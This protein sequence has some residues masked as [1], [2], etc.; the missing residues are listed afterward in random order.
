MKILKQ[1]N[2]CSVTCFIAIGVCALCAT[3]PSK[4]VAFDNAAELFIQL[5]QQATPKPPGGRV[6]IQGKEYKKE[7]VT[8]LPILSVVDHR[9]A[10]RQFIQSISTYARRQNRNFM[11]VTKDGL[12][13]LVKK[14]L[15]DEKISLPA[16]TYM[17]SIDAVMIDGLFYGR[18]AFG[19]PT[20]KKVLETRLPL[21]NQA[22]KNGIKT[23]A[24]EY[25]KSPQEAQ[26]AIKLNTA[27]GLIPFPSMTPRNVLNEIPSYPRRP[28]NENPKSILSMKDV[29]N[30]LYLRETAKFGRQDEFTLNIH[31]TNFDLVVVDIFH[32]RTPLSRQAVETLKYKKVGAKRLVFA[33]IDIG[34]ASSHRYYWKARW[35]EGSPFWIKAPVPG[36]PD[37]YFVQFS[38]PEWRRIISGNPKSYVF[39]AIKQGFDGIILEGINAYRFFEGTS[40]EAGSKSGSGGGPL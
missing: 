13:L 18:Q 19:L 10:M 7:S 14:D 39:G 37:R 31:G 23:F 25:V 38:Q 29:K 12:D 3:W 24:I 5:A 9:E 4:S 32:G 40:S 20:D 36:E 22:I 16:R 30:F 27:R 33:H 34:T 17:R 2:V 8:P 35:R 11:V 21:V 28:L 15:A 6:R 1:S 26:E